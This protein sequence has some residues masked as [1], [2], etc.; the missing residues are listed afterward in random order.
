MAET[1]PAPPP[2]VE[3][4]SASHF[5]FLHGASPGGDLVGTALDLGYPG[6]GLADRNTVAGVVRAWKALKDARDD[7]KKAGLSLQP[8]RLA[9]GAR[10]VFADGTPDIVAYPEHRRGW[11]RLTR[12][13]STGNLRS[14]KGDCLLTIEDLLAYSEGL[15]LIVLPESSRREGEGVARKVPTI[16]P[17]DNDSR[18]DAETRREAEERDEACFVRS[19]PPRLRVNPNSVSR[20]HESDD[21]TPS[22]VIPFPLRQETGPASRKALSRTLKT[23]RAACPGRVWLALPATGSGTDTRRRARLLGIAR[24]A[25]VP[26]LA[27]TD[28]L[29]ATRENRPLQDILTCIRLGTT[30]TE[31]GRRLEANAERHLKSAADMA[32]LYRDCPQAIDQT[33]RL[34]DRVGFDLGDLKY[35]Y[36][37][38]PVP[39]GWEPQ[40]WLQHLVVAAA[41]R[42]WPQG[43]PIGVLR[44][45]ADEFRLIRKM[46]YAYYFLTVHDIVRFAREQ[47][48]PILCQG[49]G[50]AANSMVCFL[51]D[52]TS[53]DPAKH[54]LLFSRFMSPDRNEPPDIDVDFEHERREEVMQYIYRRYGRERAGIVATVIHYRSRSAVREV[55]KALGLTDD[56]TSRLVSTVWGSYSTKMEDS[57]FHETGFD[58]DNPEIARLNHFVG[59]LLDA[60][61]PRHLSQHVGGYVLSQGRLDEIVPVH[62]AAMADRTFI[63]WDKDDIDALKL[64][65]VDILA[66]GMLT[67]IRKAFDLIR[68]HDGTDYDLKSVPEDQSDV[69]DMLCKG[70]SIGIFQVESRAQ[71]N[72]LPRLRPRELYDLV[73]QVAIV[74]PGP[75]QGNMVHPYLRRRQGLER[76]DFPSPAPPHPRDELR[77]LL[78]KTL[79]VPLFQEQAMKLAI[80]AAE[81]SPSEANQLRRAMATF[82]N[83]GT[84]PLFEEKMV[85]GMTRR[86]YSEEFAR[87]CFGQI[88]GFGSY[89]FPESHAQSFAILVYASAFLKR[90][91]PAAFCAALL[92]SQP[93]GFYAPA[94]IVR[95]AREH[96]VE[97]RP[98]DVTASGWDNRLEVGPNGPAVR[99]GFRQIEGF[100]EAWGKAIEASLILP[101]ADGEGDHA[102]HG[103]GETSTARYFPSTAFGGPPPH[104]RHGEE[105]ERLAR[106]VPPRAL[107]LLADADAF[108]ALDLGRRDA[109]WEVRRT[110]QDALPLFAAADARELAAEADAALPA[111]PLSE[112]VAADYQMTRMSLKA[113][114]MSFL[115]ALFRGEG[116]L[117]AAELSALPDGR[118]ARMAGVVLVRQR[119]GE[120]KAIFVTL[121]DETGVTNVLLWAADFEKYR[122]AVMASRL[123]EV[124]GIVQK[125]E[126]GVVHLMTVQVVD[127]TAEL[128]RLSAD[129]QTRQPLSRADE[130]AHPQHPRTKGPRGGHPRDVRVLPPSRDFH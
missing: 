48:P 105:L 4:V 128:S 96:D 70:D 119:P 114:P 90:R 100:K 101:I 49:R 123:M 130:F 55:G 3:L 77:S 7:A 95:D 110:P 30:I 89:G 19:A 71:M 36:P 23:L 62:H 40:K 79:G 103:G 52:V 112:E 42:H 126:E 31:A 34:L 45:L 28:A 68:D 57:R 12:L 115:R 75:I 122:A 107:R 27:T 74:R 58:L 47:D 91:H 125:S 104:A 120:G 69:Y 24:A 44:M 64:M 1:H 76:V 56:V 26:P 102:K 78:G 53:V 82:R 21:E 16:L 15:L 50:S 99:L 85:G 113:H 81:F 129:H 25:Q 5:S 17:E 116:I 51:L 63:E 108:R 29:Y 80:V 92:N 66:L 67:C 118:P 20:F 13:L 88:Q 65:K 35:E 87:R 54:Q 11:G 97:V 59:L 10:L 106:L 84:M 98:I 121:E 94:Q 32:D 2:F 86:G 37:H 46:G 22:N 41:R 60:P 8:F 33:T 117:S 124:R 39:E 111:M 38:E 61:F 109:L 6:L 43:V 18:G 72:M 73:V 9:T 127:R 83:V 93:M 14:D